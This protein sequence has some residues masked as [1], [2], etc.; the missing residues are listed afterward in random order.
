[1]FLRYSLTSDLD[2]NPS[3]KGRSGLIRDFELNRPFGLL[4]YH[5]RSCGDAVSMADVPY[6]KLHQIAGSEL[7]VDASHRPMR[8]YVVVVHF[9]FSA[10]LDQP[11]YPR[12][13]LNPEHLWFAP[14]PEPAESIRVQ[15][16]L[17][18]SP[19][20]MTGRECIFTREFVRERF[21]VG[22]IV[23]ELD[24][25]ARRLG[26]PFAVEWRG[27]IA[28]WCEHRRFNRTGRLSLA[29]GVL[30]TARTVFGTCSDHCRSR[31]SEIGSRPRTIDCCSVD[32]ALPANS[33][34]L[35]MTC[36]S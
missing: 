6:T 19:I 28:S 3:R 20:H 27:A 1:M 17:Y 10:Q 2:L 15:G 25:V 18:D 11:H 12:I 22:Y 24:N 7:A 31:K 33:T 14:Q 26:I 5:N 9:G 32:P 35:Q 16:T 8:L 36:T 21:R 4:L 13:K 29:R 34:Y 23:D 30:G